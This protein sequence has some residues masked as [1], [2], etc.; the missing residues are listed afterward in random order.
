MQISGR[1]RPPDVA[2]GALCFCC[3][4]SLLS[5]ETLQERVVAHVAGDAHLHSAG[6]GLH[7]TKRLHV[8]QS[9]LHLL[10]QSLIC[11]GLEGE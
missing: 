11:T 6:H 9:P 5:P 1:V 3:S 8:P 4:I 10:K 2:F 7:L